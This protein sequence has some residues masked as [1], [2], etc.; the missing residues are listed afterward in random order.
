MYMKVRD[1]AMAIIEVED[2]MYATS[3]LA[4]TTLRSVLGEAELDELLVRAREDQRDPQGHH[5]RADRSV[6]DRSDRGRGEGRGPAPG[7]EARDG[8]AGR[9]G[10]GTPRQGDQ[11]AGRAA[12]V[13]DAP[14]SGADA[15]AGADRAAA[16]LSPDGH[17]DRRREQL[18]DDLPYSDRDDPALHAQGLP[19]AS[20]QRPAAGQ[21][22]GDGT[23][24]VA[25]SPL[26]APGLPLPTIKV[27]E[28]KT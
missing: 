14:R 22:P 13:A 1:P 26:T 20:G 11:R 7:D 23:P 24:G 15:G 3:Q 27:E 2:Y 18:D 21:L 6:G 28:R 16:P 12:G 17:R 10:A 9:G 19:A 25:G 5:R 8:A 4:Q